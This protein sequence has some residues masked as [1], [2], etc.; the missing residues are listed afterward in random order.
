M[1]PGNQV[2]K[3]K[4]P[5]TW[6]SRA[7]TNF[8]HFNIVLP[9]LQ[10][11]SII[12]SHPKRFIWTPNFSWIITLFYCY[13]VVFYE[14]SFWTP[15]FSWIITLFYCYFVVFYEGSFWTPNFSWIITLFYCYFV[16]FYDDVLIRQCSLN[17][18]LC[19]VNIILIWWF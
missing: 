1:L 17:E 3:K 14:G 10:P 9:Q 8:L 15:N 19:G 2:T 13:F 7:N 6:L 18:Y 16:V 5:R 12:F 4:T 11:F